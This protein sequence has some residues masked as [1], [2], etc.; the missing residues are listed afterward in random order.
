MQP[1]R[2][3]QFESRKPLI[4]GS[5][6][7]ALAVAAILAPGAQ[8]GLI[9]PQASKPTP[10]TVPQAATPPPAPAPAPPTS[11][12]SSSAPSDSGPTAS[13]GDGGQGSPDIPAQNPSAT[14][15]ANGQKNTLTANVFEDI[16]GLLGLKEWELDGRDGE[17]A[18]EFLDAYWGPDGNAD[19][20]AGT[21]NPAAVSQ[22]SE[23]SGDQQDG[24]MSRSMMMKL[25]PIVRPIVAIVG[26][27][28]D[29]LDGTDGT[30]DGTD[31]TD[32]CV[33]GETPEGDGLLCV[34]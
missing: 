5:F 27:I 18:R 11:G 20:G 10:L 6:I 24:T 9:T 15:N 30:T 33:K 4:G 16:D 8:A 22:P 7:V 34:S 25:N 14:A 32:A 23:D 3:L 19:F 21:D 1:K 12:P 28:T 31:G 26:A 29:H 2:L 17:I 13:G